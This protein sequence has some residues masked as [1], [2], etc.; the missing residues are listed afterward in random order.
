MLMEVEIRASIFEVDLI[1][2]SVPLQFKAMK[3]LLLVVILHHIAD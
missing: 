1:A 3:K 2:M